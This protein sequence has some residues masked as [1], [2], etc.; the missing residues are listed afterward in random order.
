M[1]LSPALKICSAEILTA[2]LSLAISASASTLDVDFNVGTHFGGR[3][4]AV[5]KHREV[6]FLLLD[7]SYSMKSIANEVGRCNSSRDEV[8]REMLKNRLGTIAEKTPQ[9][10]I[11]V[12]TFSGDMKGP[13]GPYSAR[14]YE[15]IFSK[16][17]ISRGGNAPL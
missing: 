10:E 8:L 9:A 15:K 6:I 5:N 7:Q 16:L 14:E 12:I 17:E 13:F 11:Y 1:R 3:N 4:V 2:L